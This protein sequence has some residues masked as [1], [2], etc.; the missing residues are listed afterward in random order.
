MQV[1]SPETDILLE[2]SIGPLIIIATKLS[3]GMVEI[4]LHK[5][6]VFKSFEYYPAYSPAFD[7]NQLMFTQYPFQLIFTQYSFQLIFTQYPFFC[8]INDVN[9]DT[10]TFAISLCK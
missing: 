4:N 5:L 6:E 8:L 2:R 10:Q 7:H 1:D 3:C 9:E